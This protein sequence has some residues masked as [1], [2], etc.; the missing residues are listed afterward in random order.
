[1]S[2]DGFSVANEEIDDFEKNGPNTTIPTGV[3]KN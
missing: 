2:R 1:M 3:K